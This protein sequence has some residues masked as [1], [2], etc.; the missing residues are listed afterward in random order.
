MSINLSSIQDEENVIE[1]IEKVKS[2]FNMTEETS[3]L[4]S[5]VTDILKDPLYKGLQDVSFYHEHLLSYIDHKTSQTD[6]NNVIA[7]WEHDKNSTNSSKTNCKANKSL[8][9]LAEEEEE[10]IEIKNENSNQLNEKKY[11]P[12]TSDDEQ[13]NVTNECHYDVTNAAQARSC[14]PS[15]GQ[16]P[17]KTYS[18]RDAVAEEQQLI[19]QNEYETAPF[20][21]A[22][23]QQSGQSEAFNQV[24]MPGGNYEH[25]HIILE[26]GNKGLGFSIAGGCD[27]PLETNDPSIYITKIIPGGAASVDQRLRINDA[28]L[29]VN[30]VNTSNCSHS[31]A[32]EALKNAGEVV[33]LQIRRMVP[34]NAE[35]APDLNCLTLSNQKDVITANNK[36]SFKDES[37]LNI[38]LTKGSKGLG[39]SIAGGVGNQHIVDDNG[40]YVTKIITG[41]AAEEDGNLKVG[42]KIIAVDGRS[43]SEVTHEYAVLVLQQTSDVVCLSVTR[44]KRINHSS[45][46]QKLPNEKIYGAVE[47]HQKVYGVVEHIKQPE[48]TPIMLPPPIPE[49]LHSSEHVQIVKTP[50][51]KSSSVLDEIPP[52]LPPP[53][54]SYQLSS[55]AMY[56]TNTMPLPSSSNFNSTGDLQQQPHSISPPHKFHSAFDLLQSE[57]VDADDENIRVRAVELHRGRNGL[58]FNIIGGSATDGIFISHIT[59]GGVAHTNGSLMVGD[60]ILKVNGSD[61]TRCTHQR[62]VD[63]L[64]AAGDQVYIVAQ[65]KPAEFRKFQI[66]YAAYHK[67]PT[68]FVHPNISLSLEEFG[69][70]LQQQSAEGGGIV[71]TSH[72]LSIHVRALFDY[73]ADRDDGLP[74][75][76]LSFK[77]GDV[78]HVINASDDQWWQARRVEG[79][80]E[81][82]EYGVVPSKMRV[83]KKRK[84]QVEAGQ[85][86]TQPTFLDR[87]G[88]CSIQSRCET[89]KKSNF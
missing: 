25:D 79:D 38:Q 57:E 52:A 20:Q 49:Q 58:G 67:S 43:V 2:K 84:V 1:N 53:P 56:A 46:L 66:K 26:R 70:M 69:T 14:Q 9:N 33:R 64:K 28:I 51:A 39:F 6:E 62:A 5:Q 44:A 36:T 45:T 71:M 32:V 81:S 63:V 54:A 74:S 72:K 75:K 42:D 35:A 16:Q 48:I 30:G 83:E 65:H 68:N 40:I 77:Y 7:Y 22:Q 60:Q 13:E 21:I 11:Q 15:D 76:G 61:M 55:A 24:Y 86:H 8:K 27:N 80:H 31:E 82:E 87:Q 18:T 85:I 12:S 59:V 50:Q 23:Q 34:S 41:G 78:L 10:S 37:V 19:D 3:Q 47:E 73:E 17:M 89:K 88:I 4:F 29:S